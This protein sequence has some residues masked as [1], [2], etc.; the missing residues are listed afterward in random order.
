MRR[1][2]M[3]RVLLCLPF[4]TLYVYR[5]CNVNY[6]V[7][8][9][10]TET[11]TLVCEAEDSVQPFILYL[12]PVSTIF[13][14]LT[15]GVYLKTR[16]YKSGQDVAIIIICLCLTTVLVIRV[17]FL[18]NLE[19]D[20]FHALDEYVGKFALIAYF[21]WLNILMAHCLVKLMYYCYRY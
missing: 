10:L 12:F 2:T 13:L 8:H 1:R 16:S 3:S 17:M 11:L 6:T 4:I 5:A 19:S 7:D 14:L 18:L 9:G 15:I 20:T 21:A